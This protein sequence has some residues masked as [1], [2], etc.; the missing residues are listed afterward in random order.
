MLIAHSK[1]HAHLVSYVVIY[2][3][4]R[5]PLL[6]TRVAIGCLQSCCPAQFA[7]TIWSGEEK[8][9]GVINCPLPWGDVYMLTV[10]TEDPL[11]KHASGESSVHVC[12]CVCACVCVGVSHYSCICI[13]P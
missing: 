4:P 5:P 7:V 3:N 9:G 11:G 12:G 2:W 8:E 10:P 13:G 6:T 1:V